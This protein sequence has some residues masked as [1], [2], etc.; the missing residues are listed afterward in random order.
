[1]TVAELE[2]RM[3]GLRQEP[4]RALIDKAYAF[5]RRA[6]S[7]QRRASGEAFIEHPVAV[8]AI[9]A[10]LGL[11]P[12]TVAAG[13]L[14][15]VVEDT[16]ATLDDLR[17]EFGEE[18]AFLVDGVTKLSRIPFGSAV[19][20]QA[21]NLRK[22]FLAMAHDIR[23]ILIKLA[24]RLHNMRTLDSL[25][26]SRRRA[27]ALETLEIFAPVAH[28]LGI[29]R[30]KW[31]L[32]DLA[33]KHL[34]PR[35]YEELADSIPRRR[36]E[37]EALADQKMQRGHE[38][39]QIYDLVAVRLITDSVK[40]CYAALGAVHALWKPLPGRFKDFI[41]T[42][43]SNMYQSLHTTVVGPHGEPF[44]IQIRTRD[45]HRTAEYGI[46]AHWRYKEGP[47]G[48][49]DFDQKLSWLREILDWQRD[50]RDPR[51]FMEGLKIDI[52]S[53][54]VFVF[55]PK[56]AVIQLP[57]GSNPIDFA[58]RIHT[59]IGH[60]CTGAKINGRIATLDRPLRNGDIVE[61][62]THKQSAPS[63]DW[64][65]IARTSA[66]KNRI[67]QWFKREHREEAVELGRA[68][69][70]REARR[71]GSD[72]A[73][74]WRPDWLEDVAARFS[75]PTADDLLASVGFGGASAA[76]VVGRLRDML[77]REGGERP[78]Q[79]VPP[80]TERERDRAPERRVAGDGVRVEGVSGILVRLP[81]CCNPVPGDAIVGYVTRG[82]G[83]A[84]HRPDCANIQA[85][86]GEQGRI[87]EV[88]W[89]SV[90]AAYYP[91]ELEIH[92]LDRPGLLSDVSQIVAESHTNIL[93]ATARGG[94][95]D[96]AVIGMVLEIKNLDQVEALK[97]RILRVRDVFSVERVL[98]QRSG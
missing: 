74:L 69:L 86:R 50:L 49:S 45:M 60:H 17:G 31:Q 5:S 62:L 63:A 21:E 33:L 12:I 39:S 97:R 59:E 91:V 68:A 14:H 84:I 65:H 72:L 57:A 58:Y 28:R 52:F 1:V 80:P 64:L 25:E 47:G 46:A 13:L 18:I 76:Q 16:A 19:E 98:R 44:E 38:L 73:S 67:R 40:D 79:E 43:K 42:P 61:I 70:E 77:R 85:H 87:I 55:T 88:D 24:D 23:V 35:V 11:D 78:V 2:E 66:A 90:N 34:E 83:V 27:I 95:A 89:D 71:Q 54:E 4:D 20:A 41:A 3:T 51:E 29:F 75:F 96:G 7:G 82:R 6:H 36:E 8:A 48:D 22:M 26:E 56:G 94:K 10:E 15:D 93:Q 81:R 92:G 30:I 53:D 37:R 32:E 9:L